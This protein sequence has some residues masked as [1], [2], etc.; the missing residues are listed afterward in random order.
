MPAKLYLSIFVLAA[1]A[2]TGCN[3]AAAPSPA[4]GVAFVAPMQL[5]LRKEL[6]PKSPVAAAV[7]HGEKLDVLATRRRFIKVRTAQNIEGWTDAGSLLS[8][9]QMDGL[10]GLAN[11]C[12]NMPSQGVATVYDDL[13]IHTEPARTAPSFDKITE[14]MKVDVI[15]YSTSPKLAPRNV[16]VFEQPALKEVAKK[17]RESKKLPPPPMPK[18]PALPEN[19]LELSQVDEEELEEK[20]K[21]AAKAPPK[22]E[23]LV[24]MDDWSLIRTS[25]GKAGWVL[26][27]M[28]VMAIP[29]EVAQ[30]AEGRRIAAYLPIGEIKEK[31]VSHPNYLW[32]TVGKGLREAQFDSFRVF[33]WSTK[34]HRYETA[35]VERN[36]K[37]YFPLEASTTGDSPSFSV[38]V[39]DKK[40]GLVRKTYAFS[41]FHVR[42]IRKD[43]Y[44]PVKLETE[45]ASAKRPPTQTPDAPHQGGWSDKLKGWRQRM[46]GK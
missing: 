35:Y 11:Q 38:V 2:L 14:K 43:R 28:L 19:W 31:G 25:D 9:A 39:E 15:G 27:R 23:G 22:A 10:N 8:Q 26:A 36:V 42:L 32:A 29:D 3:T 7:K 16:P 45:L 41:G 46:F 33:V 18:A 40:A 37:G 20:E 4:I 30:Y 44:A 5:N 1:L 17:A 21:A 34:H 13:N 12:K 24:V 6:A